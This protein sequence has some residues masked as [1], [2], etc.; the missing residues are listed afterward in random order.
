MTTQPVEAP[1]EG[2]ATQP[3][4]A[5]GAGPEVLLSGAGETVLQSDSDYDLQSEPGSPVDA[6]DRSGSPDRYFNREDTIDEDLSE[7]VTYRETIRGMRPFMV[8][9]A[10]HS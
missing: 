7:D 1:S 9:L 4:K 6:N 2:M 10:Q 5:P 3:V 8:W